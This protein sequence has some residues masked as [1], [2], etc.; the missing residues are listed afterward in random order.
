MIVWRMVVGELEIWAG[1]W[2]TGV[3]KVVIKGQESAFLV[4]GKALSNGLKMGSS[5]HKQRREV[6][7]FGWTTEWMKSKR[8]KNEKVS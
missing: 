3:R 2:R 1:S 5:R 6:V 8:N 4:E 7:Q